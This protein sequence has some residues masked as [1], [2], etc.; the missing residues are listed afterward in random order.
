MP[1]DTIRIRLQTSMGLEF[2]LQT[3]EILD[4]SR[5]SRTASRVGELN[6]ACLKQ[7]ENPITMPFSL[8]NVP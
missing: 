1:K 4:R 5:L 2:E 8:P 6:G 7:S 3:L